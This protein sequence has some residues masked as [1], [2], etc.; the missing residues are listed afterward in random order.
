MRFT[1]EDSLI[2]TDIFYLL[3]ADELTVS[4]DGLVFRFRLRPGIT[5]SNTVNVRPADAASSSMVASVGPNTASAP[6]VSVTGP[7]RRS[8]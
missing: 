4:S 2:R 3:A 7:R 8:A 6:G 5:G 1:G